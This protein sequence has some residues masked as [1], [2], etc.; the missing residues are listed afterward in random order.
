MSQIL[1]CSAET[2][3]SVNALTC[4]DCIIYISEQRK[5]SIVTSLL[6]LKGLNRLN[7]G[8]L[9]VT[10]NTWQLTSRRMTKFCLK[11]TADVWHQ[12]RDIHFTKGNICMIQIIMTQIIRR[13]LSLPWNMNMS[14]GSVIFL[15]TIAVFFLIGTTA[16]LLI[17][18]H[19][20]HWGGGGG[21]V[22]ELSI[23]WECVCVFLHI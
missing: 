15:K 5:E 12:S 2:R 8:R 9:S 20:K 7:L 10:S 3:S 4:S 23:A 18:W 14:A 21:G 1:T 22:M 19:R 6:R 11:N 16:G 17:K 13:V